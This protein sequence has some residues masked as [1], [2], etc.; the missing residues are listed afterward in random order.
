LFAILRFLALLIFIFGDLIT[1]VFVE[2]LISYGEI[3][4]FVDICFN[5]RVF[6]K[7]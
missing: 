4:E 3:M 6:S 2:I 5:I 7:M 1:E